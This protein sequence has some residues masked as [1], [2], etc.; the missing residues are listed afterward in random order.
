[1]GSNTLI[2]SGNNT[3]TGGT[4]ISAGVLRVDSASAIGSSGLVSMT[5]G[6][7]QYSVNN[8]TDYSSRFSTASGQARRVDVNGQSV[9][10]STPMGG[11]S[12]LALVGSAGTLTLTEANTYTQ[13]TTLSVG[14]LKC[15]NVQSLGTGASAGLA[16][17]ND[18]TLHVAGTGGKLTLQGAYTNTGTGSRTIRIGAA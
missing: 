16:Q 10:F 6:T 11:D 14:T 4:D 13:G 18:T 12:S 3:Y 9:T 7:L 5:G 17:A 1:M 2:L 8:T 15:G